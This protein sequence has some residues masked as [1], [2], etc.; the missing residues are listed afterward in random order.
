MKAIKN[1]LSVFLLLA[2]NVSTSVGYQPKETG[3]FSIKE[4]SQDWFRPDNSN[5]HFD[6]GLPS[7][8][9]ISVEAIT[10]QPSNGDTDHVWAIQVAHV[11]HFKNLLTN[12]VDRNLHFS[13]A[14]RKID[15]LYPFHFFW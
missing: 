2:I 8:H 3:S 4:N 14:Q 10:F 11:L 5:N 1:I 7:D 9:T 6:H 15:L 13:I 12:Q